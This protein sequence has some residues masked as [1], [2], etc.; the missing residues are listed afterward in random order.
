MRE[1]YCHNTRK[2]ILRVRRNRS[3]SGKEGSVTSFDTASG[4]I[5]MLS[6]CW[7]ERASSERHAT[8][9]IRKV[10]HLSVGFC[11]FALYICQRDFLFFGQGDSDRRYRM[12]VHGH[13]GLQR[14]VHRRH[15]E[16]VTLHRL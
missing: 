5:S 4:P 15:S 6:H 8:Q 2:D 11:H 7:C 10:I 12:I 14:E 16:I 3:A 13:D 9:A 1:T